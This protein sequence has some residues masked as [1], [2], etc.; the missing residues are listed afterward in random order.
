MEWREESGAVRAPSP[1]GLSAKEQCGH[2]APFS[3]FSSSSQDSGRASQA[4]SLPRRVY[5][6]A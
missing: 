3:P 1:G 6:D 5:T 2:S 4:S